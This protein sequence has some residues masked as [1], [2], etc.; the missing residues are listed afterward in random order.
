MKL[1]NRRPI[2]IGRA[3]RTLR[4]DRFFIV[5]TDDTHA[6]RQYF[7]GLQ[8]SRVKVVVLETPEGSGESSPGHV[9]YRLWSEFEAVKAKG[10][11]QSGDEFWILL[12]TDHHVRETHL[13]GTTE[14]LRR[15]HQSDFEIAMSNP[16]F[17]LW[18]LLHH[19]NV[20]SGTQFVRCEEVE[21]RLCAVLGSYTKSKLKSEHFPLRL[22][23]EAI[24]RARALETSPDNP[25]GRW[26][27]SAGT[28]VYR[29]LERVLPLDPS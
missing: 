4:D 21:Q 5:A 28:R 3:Q 20:A 13:P 18:L 24:R 25:E 15:A 12:D 6:P 7:A 23:R 2:A 19:E 17:E 1:I 8:L 26:P 22:V 10:E 11:V 29:L 27:Q 9:V 14:A 16:C